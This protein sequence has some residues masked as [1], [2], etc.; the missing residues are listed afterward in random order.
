[1]H[2]VLEQAPETQ[3]DASTPAA[4]TVAGPLLF[5]LSSTSADE[6]RRTAQ[7]LADWLDDNNDGSGSAGTRPTRW[8]AGVGTGPCAPR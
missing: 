7:R 1:M 6:L 3:T 4:T 2:A 5:P 8:R